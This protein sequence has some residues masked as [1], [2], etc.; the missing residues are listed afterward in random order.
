MKRFGSSVI[1]MDTLCPDESGSTRRMDS[2]LRGNDRTRSG[3][4]KRD[5]GNDKLRRG[6]A[7]LSLLALLFSVGLVHAQQTPPPPPI[8]GWGFD[9][10][11]IGGEMLF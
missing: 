1:L 6:I 9:E 3:N 4:D 11:H 5:D 8:I 7:R 10:F 2:H